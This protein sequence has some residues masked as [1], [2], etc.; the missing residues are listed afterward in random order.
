MGHGKQLTQDEIWKLLE[1]QEDVLTPL[2]KKEQAF[3]RNS[4]CPACGATSH[5]QTVNTRRPF[6]QGSPLPNIILRCL[7]C[8]TEFDPNSNLILSM[9]S[10][11][12]ESD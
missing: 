2:M 8:Q 3:F 12:P 5:T 4:S 1:G 9:P 6:S 11:T 10:F 7:Q